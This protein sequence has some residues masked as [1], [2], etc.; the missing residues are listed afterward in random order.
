M[1]IETPVFLSSYCDAH[2]SIWP[3]LPL[4]R[5]LPECLP[6]SMVAAAS[7]DSGCDGRSKSAFW[8]A[9]DIRKMDCHVQ[10]S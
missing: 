4:K 3:D 7:K 1:R 5:T 2:R 8:S 10:P 6:F 9:S